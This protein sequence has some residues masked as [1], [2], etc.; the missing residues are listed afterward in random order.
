[1]YLV[2]S[3]PVVPEVVPPPLLKQCCV[4]HLCEDIFVNISVG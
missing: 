2:I 3:L 1:M 4:E